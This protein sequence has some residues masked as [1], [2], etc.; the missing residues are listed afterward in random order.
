MVADNETA[1]N[2][3]RGEEPYAAGLAAA[4]A[5]A[6]QGDLAGV[7]EALLRCGLLV[8]LRH[9]LIRRATDLWGGCPHPDDVET[10]IGEAIEITVKAVQAGRCER[11]GSYLYKVAERVFQKDLAEARRHAAG[12]AGLTTAPSA[13][14][15]PTEE[16]E[17]PGRR[18]ELA[19]KLV[20]RLIPQLG[21]E[22]VQQVMS[23]FLEAA[24]EGVADLPNSR[25]AEILG[26]TEENVKKSRQ[27][28]MDRLRRKALAEGFDRRPL[29]AL[30]GELAAEG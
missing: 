5:R 1:E 14:E 13:L 20:E 28:G 29:E 2:R 24:R 9:E 16:A 23:L 10:S 8:G 18:R 30:E 3:E 17:D 27:R 12:D 6:E 26:L 7:L 25:V 22:N 4:Q 21:Q 19:F 15:G 11:F